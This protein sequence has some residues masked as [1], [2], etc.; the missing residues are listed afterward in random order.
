[1]CFTRQILRHG[2]FVEDLFHVNL[3]DCGRL[4]VG[5]I[6]DKVAILP[7]A[8]MRAGGL[9]TVFSLGM[10]LTD[11]GDGLGLSSTH[12]CH[13]R[14][15]QQQRSRT[16]MSTFHGLGRLRFGSL[17]PYQT[18]PNSLSLILTLHAGRSS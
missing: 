15:H 18:K 12:T 2:R 11:D 10:T 1:M 7:C 13:L 4:N 9:K 6:I 8:G 14:N 5:W 16:S 3:E 17:R